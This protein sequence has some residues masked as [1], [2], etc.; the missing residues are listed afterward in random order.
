MVPEVMAFFEEPADM[1]EKTLRV[2]RFQKSHSLR[3][4]QFHKITV[5][6]TEI[7]FGF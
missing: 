5:S 6:S 3:L 7:I 1:L 4:A 2:L